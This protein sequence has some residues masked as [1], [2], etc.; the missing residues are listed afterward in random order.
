[1][2]PEYL[3]KIINFF[4]HL[5]NSF[6]R[7][8]NHIGVSIR[9]FYRSPGSIFLLVIYPMILL[10]LF[11]SIFATEDVFTFHLEVQ[12]NDGTLFSEGL[13]QELD[14]QG[15][16]DIH[17][18]DTSVD[19]K[20]YLQENN[21][22]SCLVIPLNWTTNSYNP[23]ITSSNVTL[24]IDPNSN[25]A[26]RVANIVLKT[27]KG[28]SLSISG[29]EPPV[30]ITEVNFY[31][32]SISY[33]DFF[34]PGIIGVIIMNT[35]ILGVI[36]RQVHFKKSGLFR[37]L[38]TTPITR[39]EYATA[40][41]GWQ[42]LIAF[43]TTLLAFLVAWA[44]FSFSWGSFDEL[45]P[46]ILFVG[47]LAFSGIGLIIS[48]LVRNPNNTLAVGTLVTLPMMFLS[49]IFFD[50]SGIKALVIISKFSP[51]TYIVEALRSSMINRN[52]SYAWLNIGIA[53]AIGMTAFVVGVFLTQWNQ[54][55]KQ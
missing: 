18:L 28:Y 45:I 51:L 54:D 30:G 26:S 25:V 9:L 8:R 31:S 32:D 34:I 6:R 46:V 1:M 47:V 12:D 22:H 13:I 20:E 36:N 38:A 50:I 42:Y 37:K 2:V 14:N 40:E 19:P 16:L 43:F 55:K 33:I 15:I 44:V 41:I 52:F 5:S 49:G 10:L 17:R 3:Q 39:W 35:G 27:V 4:T 23:T 53:F 29:E 21:L 24:I 7:I 11:G 48:Q